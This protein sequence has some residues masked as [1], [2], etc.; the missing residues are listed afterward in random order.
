MLADFLLVKSGTNIFKRV[1]CF[2]E[3]C[4]DFVQ[5]CVNKH[6]LSK[7]LLSL[8]KSVMFTTQYVLVDYSYMSIQYALNLDNIERNHVVEMINLEYKSINSI[9][10]QFFFIK[11]DHELSMSTEFFSSMM[12]KPQN[13]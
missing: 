1:K 6:H 7:T 4:V 13:K 5:Y 3:M 2:Y 10:F 8:L 9:L 12:N 11:H